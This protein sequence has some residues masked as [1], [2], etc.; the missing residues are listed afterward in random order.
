MGLVILLN[1][2]LNVGA[3]T[4]FAISGNSR[5]AQRFVFWQI[6]GGVFGLGTQISY[7]GLVRFST[8]ELANAIGIGLAFVST[9]F[10]SAYMYFHAPFTGWQCF[11]TLLVFVGILCI[12]LGK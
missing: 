10:F 6:V 12:A 3:T 8:V 5:T 9:E 11:G 1:Q 2:A 7:A 4:G